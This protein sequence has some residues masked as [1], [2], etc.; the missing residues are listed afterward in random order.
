MPN[1]PQI[2]IQT[3]LSDSFLQQFLHLSSNGTKRA[4]LYFIAIDLSS[5]F[6]LS[7]CHPDRHISHTTTSTPCDP[8]MR[9]RVGSQDGKLGWFTST[10]VSA[11]RL[12]VRETR[13]RRFSGSEGGRD[14]SVIRRVAA[15]HRAFHPPF[16]SVKPEGHFKSDASLFVCGDL[17]GAVT[18]RHTVLLFYPLF[19][20]FSGSWCHFVPFCPFVARF[21]RLR[22]AKSDSPAL[23]RLFFHPYD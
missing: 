22:D 7:G 3:F 2:D 16:A 6:L 8:R 23:P 19:R 10:L 17:D 12:S 13:E 14:S 18:T 4:L 21:C 5:F 11:I 9:D 1:L 20:C 15:V